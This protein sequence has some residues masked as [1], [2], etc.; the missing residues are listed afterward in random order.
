[1][2]ATINYLLRDSS[3]LKSTIDRNRTAMNS[4]GFTEDVYNL[5][6]AK[7]ENLTTK[8]TI[9]EVATGNSKDKSAAQDELVTKVQKL[10][11]DAKNAAKSA[12]G[13]D[14]RQLI[15][16]RIGEVIPKS[17][18]NLIPLCNYMIEQVN[19]CKDELLKNGF[20]QSKI[21][22]LNSAPNNLE[23]A[24]AEQESAR[25]IKKSRTLERDMAVME[26]KEVVF[27]IRSFA[28]VCFGNAPEILEQFKPIPKGRGAEEEEAP[29]TEVTEVKQ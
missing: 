5:L 25:I 17:V 11:S 7:A 1:M 29:V 4:A 14:K 9:Q 24:D 13:N 18:K 26:L 15:L 8:E 27:K 20:V 12:Y 19:A 10:I 6:I 3:A 28:K 22:E 2:N 21:D 23:A 16:F